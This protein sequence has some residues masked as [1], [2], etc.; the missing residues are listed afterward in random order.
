MSPKSSEV[1]D[2]IV[3][4]CAQVEAQMGKLRRD[5]QMSVYEVCTGISNHISKDMDRF[6]YHVRRLIDQNAFLYDRV[7][8]LEKRDDSERVSRRNR[9]LHNLQEGQK[10]IYAGSSENLAPV[11]RGGARGRVSGHYRQTG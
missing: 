11:Q 1:V 10:R 7:V 9:D 5:Y 2:M 8:A 4:L 3:D 6:I